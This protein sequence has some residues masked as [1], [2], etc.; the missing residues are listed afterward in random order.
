MESDLITL[1]R[2]VR[3][4][5]L[6]YEK[7]SDPFDD[8]RHV[9]SR[10]TFRAI[11]D[12]DPLLHDALRRWVHELLQVR[13]GS[14]LATADE[15]AIHRVDDR[16]PARA[17]AELPAKTYAEAWSRVLTEDP[18]L[19]ALER[20]AELAL[21]VAAVR[22]ERR[23]RRFEAARRLDLAHPWSLAIPKETSLESVAREMLDA[24]ELVAKDVIRAAQKV[25]E[26]K[27]TAACAMHFALATD[28]REG[29]PARLGARWLR[30]VFRAVSS[31]D[32]L[33]AARGAR[34]EALPIGAADRDRL[35]AAPG[36]IDAALGGA[37]F[38]RAAAKWG[39]ALRAAGAPR[40]LPFS[41]SRDPYPVHAHRFAAAFAVAVAEPSFQRRMLGLSARVAAAQSRSLRRSLL[42]A[43]RV[44][45]A[46][47][48]LAARETVDTT[49]FEELGM[50]LFG[51]PLPAALAGAW[52]EPRVDEP[53][54]LLAILHAESFTRTIVDRFDEDWYANPRAGAWLAQIAAAPAF[55]ADPREK[56]APRAIAKRFEE[57]LG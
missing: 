23:A 35:G 53:A 10:A 44:Q 50:R 3:A 17:R 45:A 29:W 48:L 49:L 36:A 39:F 9:A 6:R 32:A 8:V 51:A 31:R 43:V 40:S 5:V 12:A 27:W 25:H 56:K 38:L 33:A 11:G 4:A 37:S 42:F 46:R 18:S 55:D 34:A 19:G 54:R 20:V 52:P 14:D 24:T 7:G 16:L 30:E 28:A 21:P 41:L 1:D 15:E 13:V 22:K 47:F 26:G 2:D 57:A